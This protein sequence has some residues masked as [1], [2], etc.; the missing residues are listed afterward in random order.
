M[1]ISIRL[2]RRLTLALLFS[3]PALAGEAEHWSLQ[4]YLARFPEQQARSEAFSQ[5]IRAP[6]EPWQGIDNRPVRI[7]MLSPGGQL[8]DY[9]RRNHRSLAARL[10]EIAIPYR[11]DS[12]FVAQHSPIR[13]QERLLADILAQDPDYLVL[14]LDSRRHRVLIE[15][16]LVRDRPKLILQNITTPLKAWQQRQPLLYVGFDHA[17]GT[18]Q[19]AASLP[20]LAGAPVHYLMLYGTRGHVSLA[21]GDEFIR[22][23]SGNP[24]FHLRQQ[25][26]TDLEPEKTRAAVLQALSDIPE[27]NLIYASTTDIALASIQALELAGRKADV[28]VNGWG[29]GQDELDALRQGRLDLTVMRM[30][31]DSGVAIAE[32]IRLDREGK[33]DAIPGVYSGDFAVVTQDTPLAELERLKAYAFR[34]SR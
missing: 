5:R 17:L 24:D 26:Y 6:A 7:A 31:D 11:L 32:A 4:D 14:T 29:G 9:W 3:W 25:V 23:M 16:L 20:A 8:S 15:K 33:T 1:P 19:L 22:L 21:R 2:A 27:L 10:D 12:H 28:I 30:N 18:R 34:Y 13:E